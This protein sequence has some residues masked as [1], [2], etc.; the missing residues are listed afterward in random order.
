M[1]I[2]SPEFYIFLLAVVLV[3]FL[4][5]RKAQWGVLLFSSYLFYFYVSGWIGIFLGVTTITSFFA[6]KLIH[7]EQESLSHLLKLNPS[8]DQKKNLRDRFEKRKKYWILIYILINFGILFV[9]KYSGFFESMILQVLRFTNFP[10]VQFL[11][12]LGIS[13]Y[14]FQAAS[15]VFD[16]SRGHIEAEKNIFKMALFIGFFPQLTLGPISR[17]QHLADQLTKEHNFDVTRFKFGLQLILWGL[18]K[19]MVIADRIDIFVDSV[20]NNYAQYKGLTI[21]FGALFYMVQVYADFSGAIDIVRGVSKIFGINMVSNFHQPFFAKSIS[22]FWRRW[23]ITLGGWFKEYVFYPLA[24]SRFFGSVGK[25]SR[26]VFPQNYAKLIPPVIAM[27]ITFTLIGLWHGPNMTYVAYGFYNG[28]FII[29]GI[30]FG[31]NFEGEKVLGLKTHK[32]PWKIIQVLFT[33]F[34]GGIG[35]YIL[36]APSL[37]D[38]AAMLAQT[39]R[40][41][42]LRQII[43]G[44]LFQTELGQ[45]EFAVFCIAFG[46]MLFVEVLHAKGFK[47]R[48]WIATQPI[49]FRWTIYFSAI[50]I[51]AVFGIYGSEYNPSD[52]IYRAF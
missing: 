19:K 18:I 51:L 11:L 12:P 1:T 34:I 9:I 45:K 50:M 28:F 38:T 15:Y 31:S 36:R 46:F 4:V 14:T 39:I 29:L 8:P 5:P 47:I 30:L 6:G 10:E 26:K 16:V 3:Y 13:F 40:T 20:F 41:F 24:L 23:H 44:S 2:N 42:D 17:Y 21:Y 27:L 37:A 7:N 52:F 22:D 32:L 43:D 48:A 49:V 33:L 25:L 35:R